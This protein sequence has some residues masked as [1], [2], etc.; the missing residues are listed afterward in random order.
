MAQPEKVLVAKPDSLNSIPGTYM[1][2]GKK[3]LVKAVFWSP[4]TDTMEHVHPH[5]K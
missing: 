5:S 2:E 4:H 1:V 3:G